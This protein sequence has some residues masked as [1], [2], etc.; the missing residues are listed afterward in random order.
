MF[1]LDMNTLTTERFSAWSRALRSSDQSA[2]TELFEATND[3]LFRYANFIIK[4]KEAAYDVLQ[5]VYFKLWQIRRQL[6][7][8]RSL[9]A[10]LYQMVRNRALNYMQRGS[11]I[12]EVR[13]K[14][15]FEGLSPDATP[16][17]EFDAQ[18]LS[19]RIRRWVMELPTRR[20]E[21]FVLSRYEGLSHAEIAQVMRLTPKTVNNHIVLA[22]AH[23]RKKLHAHAP[24]TV[25]P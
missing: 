10:L 15:G 17:L 16:D 24:D 2:Y 21:A 7:P 8:S 18:Q 25:R 6:D 19:E 22:L 23:L 5:D 14:P 11:R 4:D 12:R 20:R 3:A 1:Y 13:M 9:K